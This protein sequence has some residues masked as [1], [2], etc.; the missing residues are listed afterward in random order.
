MS[1]KNNAIIPRV[2]NTNT[3][4][5]DILSKLEQIIEQNEQIIEENKNLV[6]KNDELLI[7]NVELKTSLECT[8][9]ALNELKFSTT[10]ISQNM[11]KIQDEISKIDDKITKIT[12][13]DS[14]IKPSNSIKTSEQN[15]TKRHT[16]ILS[17]ENE[18]DSSNSTWSDIARTNITKKLSNV[19]INKLTLTKTGQYYINLPNK[20]SQERAIECLKEDFKVKAETKTIGLT[21][22]ITICDLDPENYCSKSQTKLRT[23]ILSKNMEI[24]KLVEEGK[25]FEIIFIKEVDQGNN[26]A[27]VKIDPEILNLL[28]D[29]SKNKKSNAVIFIGNT[30]CRFY[31]RF[32]ILQCYRCQSFGHKKGSSSCPLASSSLNTCLYCSKNH[33][34]KECKYKKQPESFKCANCTR[35]S[36]EEDGEYNA[37]HTTTDH[38]CPIYQKQIEHVLKRTRGMGQMSKNE[39]PKHVFV[40]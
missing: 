18:A 27:V 34:S 35:F 23:D 2:P 13:G 26:Q 14:F 39:F 17:P 12:K 29:L 6:K 40:T 11:D 24:Q 16:I 36:S 19:Q 37:C 15:E 21:P 7:I 32:H 22:K 1:N 20:K 4:Q 38:S 30:V 8:E 31:N 5:K 9:K 28:N 33:P 25:T 3:M 10:N